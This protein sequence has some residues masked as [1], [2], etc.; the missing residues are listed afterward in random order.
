[1]AVGFPVG[2]TDGNAVGVDVGTALGLIVGMKVGILEGAADGDCEGANVGF[3]GAAVGAY[4]QLSVDDDGD[5]P[6]WDVEH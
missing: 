2:S 6:H 1:M 4:T 3:E 5:S